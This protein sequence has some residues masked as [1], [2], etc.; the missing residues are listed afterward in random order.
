MGTR[1]EKAQDPGAPRSLARW[2][3]ESKGQ[4]TGGKAASQGKNQGRGSGQAQHPRGHPK[5]QLLR[6]PQQ[7]SFLTLTWRRRKRQLRS[8]RGGQARTKSREGRDRR[9]RRAG[10][11]SRPGTGL[12]GWPAVPRGDQVGAAS[13]AGGPPFLCALLSSPPHP[14]STFTLSFQPTPKNS[15]PAPDALLCVLPR[16]HRDLSPNPPSLNQ[17]PTP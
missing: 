15:S 10:P 1:K 2:E 9:P 12:C 13:A 11:G 5:R 16:P 8:G 7:P 4:G 6:Q 14:F 3:W 17:S